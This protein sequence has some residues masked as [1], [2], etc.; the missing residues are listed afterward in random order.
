MSRRRLIIALTCAFYALQLGLLM[1]RHSL[2]A[3][4]A[5]S[6]DAFVSIGIAVV[7]GLI[8]ANAARYLLGA[9]NRSQTVYATDASA[10]LERSLERYRLEAER[11]ERFAQEVGRAVEEEL[12]RARKAIAQGK[13]AEANG[14]IQASLGIASNMRPPYCDN[15]AVA[16]VLDSKNRQCEEAD[17]DLDAKVDIPSELPLPEVEVAAV[18]FNL[19]DNAMHECE[20]LKSEGVDKVAISVRAGIQAGQLFIEVRNPCRVASKRKCGFDSVLRRRA[21]G[22]ANDAGVDQSAMLRRSDTSHEHGWGTNIVRTI[23]RDHG[24]IVEYSR[25]DAIFTATVMIPLPAEILA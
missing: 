17:I 18:F 13:S 14:H 6:I 20:A 19:I 5:R 22:V 4:D 23:A 21:K 8:D 9:L 24:G 12:S 1:Y 3:S 11:D 2:A 15:V 25:R 16:A 7:L 10:R